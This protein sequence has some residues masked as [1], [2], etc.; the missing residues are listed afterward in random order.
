MASNRFATMLLRRTNKMT[1][2]LVYVALEWFLILVLLLNSLFSHLIVKYAEFFGLKP[3][4]LWCTRI[5]HII[6]PVNGNGNSHR[7]LLCEA[8]AEEVSKLG[9][10]SIHRKLAESHDMC[11]D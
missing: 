6:D 5:E 4:C 9:F 1:V 3:P 8:H 10:C 7:D 11:Q 2:I